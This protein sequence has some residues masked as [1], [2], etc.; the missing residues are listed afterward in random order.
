VL[1]A[2]GERDHAVDV[3]GEVDER[4]HLAADGFIADPE[5]EVVAPLE[6]FG[7]VR[8]GEE[9][10]ADSLGV[11]AEEYRAGLLTGGVRRVWLLYFGETLRL[12]DRRLPCMSFFLLMNSLT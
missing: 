11:H 12:R 10:G 7:D 8:E 3:G 1:R 4:E 9:K 5:D 2:G 6:G